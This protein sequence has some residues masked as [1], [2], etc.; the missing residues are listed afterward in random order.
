MVA[1]CLS[2]RGVRVVSGE[3]EMNDSIIES[4]DWV[5]YEGD[6]YEALDVTD[7]DVIILKLGTGRYI[8]QLTT[9]ISNVRKMTDSDVF[10]AVTDLEGYD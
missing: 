7:T 5:W 4:G 9:D 2:S 8:K 10:K 6:Y 3:I 1:R